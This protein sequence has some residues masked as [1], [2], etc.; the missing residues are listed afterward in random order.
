MVPP[1]ALD[2]LS[3]LERD[4]NVRARTLTNLSQLDVLIK[5]CL[6]GALLLLRDLNMVALVFV[7]GGFDL[8]AIYKGDSNTLAG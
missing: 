6:D 8:A 4:N 1:V 3:R 2:Y 5:D 7:R